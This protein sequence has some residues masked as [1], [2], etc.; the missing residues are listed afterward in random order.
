MSAT[1]VAAVVVAV[2][3]AV[4]AA[5]LVRRRQ[6]WPITIRP[7]ARGFPTENGHWLLGVANDPA[8][9]ECFDAGQRRLLDVH[10][11]DTLVMRVL[12]IPMLVTRDPALIRHILVTNSDNYAKPRGVLSGYQELE[13]FLGT[14]LL[15]SE[16]PVWKHHRK[17][18]NPAFAPAYLRGLIPVFDRVTDQLVATLRAAT[19]A[20]HDLQVLFTKTTIDIIGE[21]GF[22]TTFG[23]LN[24]EESALTRAVSVAL[25]ELEKRLRNPLHVY[26]DR[27][28]NK[29]FDDSVAL[30]HGV[31][32]KVIEQK[33]RDGTAAEDK[34]I[35]GYLMRAQASGL[36][37]EDQFTDQGLIDEIMTL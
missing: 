13:P 28:G 7:A 1:V 19:N 18:V 37:D 34:S 2:V 15:L 26:L 25:L 11:T 36:N 20:V 32:R 23:A 30:L 3:V 24:S 16:G 21:A 14:G 22:G 33:R 6:W 4:L 12:L 27:T 31:I 5:A 17:I 8:V 29:Q 10:N 35:L 9:V